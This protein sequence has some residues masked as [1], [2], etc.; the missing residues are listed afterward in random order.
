LVSRTTPVR[1]G[2]LRGLAPPPFLRSGA[3]FKSGDCL[4]HLRKLVAMFI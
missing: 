2:R 3:P 4:F 1:L